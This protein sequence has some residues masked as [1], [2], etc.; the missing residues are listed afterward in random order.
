MLYN[1]TV[2]KTMLEIDEF[3]IRMSQLSKD[4]GVPFS[5]DEFFKKVEHTR[6]TTEMNL[7]QAFEHEKKKIILK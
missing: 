2:A 6:L 1:E 7:E 4:L 5:P 3:T